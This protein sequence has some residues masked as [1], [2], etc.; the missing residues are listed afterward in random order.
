[1]L[2]LRVHRRGRPR[3]RWRVSAGKNSKRMLKCKNWRS[4]EDT[5]ACRRTEEAKAQVGL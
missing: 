4:A 5:Y 3:G 1:M 2:T